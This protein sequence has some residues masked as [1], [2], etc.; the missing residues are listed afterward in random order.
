MSQFASVPV[1]LGHVP[2]VLGLPGQQM[3]PCFN[4]LGGTWPGVPVKSSIN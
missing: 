1:K 2:D 4:S 3:L